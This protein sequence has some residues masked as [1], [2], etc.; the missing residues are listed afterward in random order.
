MFDL[1]TE[2]RACKSLHVDT[3]SDASFAWRTGLHICRNTFRSE[4]KERKKKKNILHLMWDGL[5][6]P[7]RGLG[8]S[9]GLNTG[10]AGKK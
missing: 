7:L 10:C 3:N 4:Q 6:H 1:Y 2:L 8:L 9:R 5:T